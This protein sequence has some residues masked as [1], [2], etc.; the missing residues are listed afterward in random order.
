MIDRAIGIMSRNGFPST[1]WKVVLEARDDGSDGRAALGVLCSQYWYPIYAFVRSRVRDVHKAQDL[2]QGFFTHLL[3]HGVVANADQARGRFRDFLLG[4]C[5]NYLLGHWRWLRAKKRNPGAV[6]PLPL[7]FEAAE[8]R[9]LA[10]GNGPD[11]PEQKYTRSWAL[12]VLERT[13][14]Q[15]RADYTADGQTDLF[16][17]LGRTL[18]GDPGAEKY[19]EI[20]AALGLTLDQVKKAA[21]RLRAA[22]KTELHRQVGQTVVDP[23]DVAAEIHELFRAVGPG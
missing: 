19:A 9:Y 23:A 20:G 18:T 12:E 14:N 1:E 13:T 7:D 8:V 5:R 16:D 6:D 11:D 2:T 15:L 22:F 17:R 3:S 4:C 10:D 21:G